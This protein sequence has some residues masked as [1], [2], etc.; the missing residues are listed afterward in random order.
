MNIFIKKSFL[1][2]GLIGIVIP[3]HAEFGWPAVAENWAHGLRQVA[4][5][6]INTGYD[7]IVN[8]AVQ[9]K[10]TV[11]KQIQKRPLVAVGVA[12]GIGAV[13]S[14]AAVWCGIRKS[15]DEAKRARLEA[16][17]K[18]RSEQV[19]NSAWKKLFEANVDR[20]Q[21]DISGLTKGIQEKELE[22]KKQQREYLQLQEG[23]EQYFEQYGKERDQQESNLV[24]KQ[25]EQCKVFYDQRQK[26]REVNFRKLG[27]GLLQEKRQLE[28]KLGGYDK[29]N[30]VLS[31]QLKQLERQKNLLVV[32]NALLL[33]R[34]KKLR[35]PAEV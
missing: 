8:A 17:N 20:L 11:E 33:T 19:R 2:I 32:G 14:V 31:L 23:C 29:A 3:A 9:A 28:I 13:L 27:E 16:E 22:I 7:K 1:V 34:L 24:A 21:R 12:A 10:K 5:S 18:L 15:F 35:R 4:S 30:D 26:N 6:C 25:K